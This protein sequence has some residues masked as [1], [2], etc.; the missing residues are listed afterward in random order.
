M[1]GALAGLMILALGDSHMVYMASP[2]HDALA[3]QGATVDLYGMCGTMPVDWLSRTTTQCSAERR[4]NA[5]AIVKNQTSQGWLL[6]DLINQAHPNMIV[7]ELGDNMAGYGTL[8][9]LPR[10]LIAA[11]VKQFLAPIRARNLPCVWIG[12]PWG[13]D[14]TAYHKTA[15]RAK[16]LSEFLAQQVAPCAYVDTTAMA[17]PG[18]WPTIDGEHLTASSYH[19]WSTDIAGA[20]AR[21]TGSL[22]V[23]ANH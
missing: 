7:V 10:D 13:N 19:K 12:P 14:T 4:G 22:H 16:E 23:A 8:P 17:K 9:Q 15:Q 2:L 18:E 3:A 1:S 20:V 21:L 5:P 11:Q 6:N